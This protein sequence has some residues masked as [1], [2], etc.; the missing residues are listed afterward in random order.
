M[1]VPGIPPL[2]SPSNPG[3]HQCQALDLDRH[4]PSRDGGLLGRGVHA[5][6]EVQVGRRG[7]AETLKKK[8]N[9]Y[10]RILEVTVVSSECL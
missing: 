10:I 3:L 6:K 8:K 2:L 4:S 5:G 7:E 1:G 9:K